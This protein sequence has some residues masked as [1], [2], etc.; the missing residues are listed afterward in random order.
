MCF[1]TYRT[2][3]CYKKILEK[4]HIRGG[5]DIQT[6]PLGRIE[7]HK[8]ALG[9]WSVII[10]YWYIIRQDLKKKIEEKSF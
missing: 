9:I 3:K 8:N 6:Y 4:T 2:K 7:N 10:M 5:W 1:M